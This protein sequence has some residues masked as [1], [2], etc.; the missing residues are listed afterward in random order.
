MWADLAAMWIDLESIKHY[1]FD[2]P[3]KESLGFMFFLFKILSWHS[4]SGIF[5]CIFRE[6]C[7]KGIN[8]KWQ[9]NT[10]NIPVS[11]IP[12]NPTVQFHC[13]GYLNMKCNT[14]QAFIF[15]SIKTGILCV[16]MRVHVCVTAYVY[17]CDRGH[18]CAER[19]HV[20]LHIIFSKNSWFSH[21]RLCCENLGNFSL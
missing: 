5:V 8:Q 10:A 14:S 20:Y 17:T 6:K 9:K 18:L 1:W 3:E 13:L 2:S 12:C 7:S 4:N 16:C 19:D 21:R 15:F 11:P